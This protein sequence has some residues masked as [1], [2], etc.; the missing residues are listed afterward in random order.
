METHCNVQRRLYDYQVSLSTTPL[1]FE[2]AHQACMELYNTTAHQGLL[3]DGC[4]PPIPLVVL[5][6]AK[7]RRYTPEAL[8]R[9]FSRTRLPRTTNP[10]GCVTLH[11]YHFDVEQGVPQTQVL[12]W[13][14]GEQL[15]AVLD[16]VVV[17]EDH[18][19]DDWRT[20]KVTEIRDGVCYPTRFASPQGAL[21]PLTPQESWVLYRPQTR[22][23]QAHKS[24]STQQLVLFELVRTG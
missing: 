14:Y 24:F 18:C 15:R 20:H 16:N 3:K 8:T 13:V 11:S 19:R 4:D 17:A 22:R 1:E 21:I 12:L 6:E 10:Y 7:G 2:Q 23:R 5:G 9:K